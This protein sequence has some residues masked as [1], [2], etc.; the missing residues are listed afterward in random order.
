METIERDLT[1]AEILSVL[2]DLLAGRTQQ[3]FGESRQ[4][5]AETLQCDL[6]ADA[7]CGVALVALSTW[8]YEVA[9]GKAGVIALREELVARARLLIAKGAPVETR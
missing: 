1:D 2:F 4:W 7:A 8:F 5:W 6:T 3:A 9:A